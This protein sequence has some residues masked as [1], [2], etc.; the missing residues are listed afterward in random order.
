M[1]RR[2]F[3]NK[4]GLGA[5]T[6]VSGVAAHDGITKVHHDW[7]N[8]VADTLDR[9]K[10]KTDELSQVIASTAKHI[11]LAVTSMATQMMSDYSK[12]FTKVDNRLTRIEMRQAFLVCWV[13]ALSV[14]TGLDFLTPMFF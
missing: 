10:E 8:T 12:Q 6:S 2:S 14:V 3:I 11:D 5:V 1:D 4:F 7:A 9:L 13:M